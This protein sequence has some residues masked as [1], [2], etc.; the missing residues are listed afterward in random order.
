[1]N[2]DKESRHLYTNNNSQQNV[3]TCESCRRSRRKSSVMNYNLCIAQVALTATVVEVVTNTLQHTHVM[4][5][6]F[7]T[8]HKT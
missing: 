4:V 1:M 6:T 3:H 8:T 2:Q 7:V 5:S